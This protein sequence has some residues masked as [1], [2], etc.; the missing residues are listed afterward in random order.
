[1][2]KW[3]WWVLAAW[4]CW[5]SESVAGDEVMELSGAAALR[6]ALLLHDR[7]MSECQERRM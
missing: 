2:L 5:D 7:S 3:V 6:A 4:A 1:M